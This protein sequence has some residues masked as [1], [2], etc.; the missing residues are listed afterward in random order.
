MAKGILY[1]PRAGVA[2]TAVTADTVLNYGDKIC[3]ILTPD[4]AWTVR[5]TARAADGFGF[6]IRNAASVV[7]R[8]LAITD[9]DDNAV[10]TIDAGE[11]YFIIGNGGSFYPFAVNESTL[12]ILA[13]ADSALLTMGNAGS[14]DF[15]QTHNGTDTVFDSANA[16]AK[17]RFR[18]GTNTT[19][20]Q[21]Q[22]ENDSGTPYLTIKGDGATLSAFT[23]V[24][25][26]ASGA[27]Q[28]NSSAGAISIGNDAVAQA[29]NLGTGG[30]RAI[31][32]GS[33]SAV[34]LNLDAVTTVTDG[35]TSGTLRTVGG[36]A[37][38]PVAA[39][40]N[41]TNTVSET[42]FSTSYTAPANS[43]KVGSLV[44]IRGY[45]IVPTTNSTDTLTIKVYF[46]TVAVLTTAA[47][48]V[49][50]DDIFTFDI[51]LTV[52]T[53]G[54]SGTFVGCCFYQDPD[55]AGTAPRWSTVADNVDTTG[56]VAIKASATWSVADPGNVCN[57][58]MLAVTIH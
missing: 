9:V 31:T 38:N 35:V 26:D 50:N 39:S 25:L 41:V 55:A 49:A 45:G 4:S 2:S 47:V 27:V 37:Y 19:A 18:M 22:V 54:A 14:A 7:G 40:S 36:R 52:R 23:T 46:G 10:V 17:F 53:T 20:T 3:Q 1:G 11:V 12:P 8:T 43:F 24:D 33:P 48:D 58:Q 6:L 29:L 5:I 30:A 13:L 16:T 51:M 56:T 57:L 44:H 21:W 28:V 15:S 42:D 32:V 34:A